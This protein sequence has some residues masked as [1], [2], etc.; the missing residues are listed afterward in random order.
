MLFIFA[1]AGSIVETAYQFS[2]SDDKNGTNAVSCV[3][4]HTPGSD[5][6]TR[7]ASKMPALRSPSLTTSDAVLSTRVRAI[8]GATAT[9]CSLKRHHISK[10]GVMAAAYNRT[11]RSGARKERRMVGY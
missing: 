1:S 5:S 2:Q 11:Y 10:V 3:P 7:L 9:T 4:L 8:T 6:R